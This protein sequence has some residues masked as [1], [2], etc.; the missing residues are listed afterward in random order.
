MRSN[1]DSLNYTR[2]PQMVSAFQ[3]TGDMFQNDDPEWICNAIQEGS[4]Y[5][6]NCSD[7]HDVQ[8]K[9]ETVFGVVT[10]HRGDY[11]VLGNDG[12]IYPVK[13]NAFDRAYVQQSAERVVRRFKTTDLS[14]ADVCDD[15]ITLHELIRLTDWSDEELEQIVTLWPQGSIKLGSLRVERVQ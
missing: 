1:S 5:F 7:S 3:W 13:E 11:I 6:S 4:V 9:I 2:V 8:M 15:N 14:Q 12:N 10:A